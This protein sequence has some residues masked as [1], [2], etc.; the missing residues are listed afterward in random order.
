[1]IQARMK[2]RVRRKR[3]K[4]YGEIFLPCYDPDKD[5]NIIDQSVAM[6]ILKGET[7]PKIAREQDVKM[8]WDVGANIGVTALYFSKL[9]PE[10]RIVCF[11]PSMD[12]VLECLLLNTEQIGD[13]CQLHSYGLANCNEIRSMNEWGQS[14]TTRSCKSQDDELVVDLP[15]C[16]FRLSDNPV[17]VTIIKIDTEGCEVEILESLVHRSNVPIYYV[18][19]HSEKDRREIDSLLPDYHL[20]RCQSDTK[21]RG[22]LCYVHQDIKTNEDKYEIT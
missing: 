17:G 7:Y 8:I 15:S 22:N 4:D 12:I 1:M 18:E 13:R 5:V 16:E 11:E 10:A 14:T 19:Y 9:Y 20:V 2:P 6:E 3:V 21:H